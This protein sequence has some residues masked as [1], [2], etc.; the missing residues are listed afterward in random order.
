MHVRPCWFLYL[1]PILQTECWKNT[2]SDGG[3]LYQEIAQ[4]YTFKMFKSIHFVLKRQE[5]FIINTQV[6]RLCPYVCLYVYL[7]FLW[8]VIILLVERMKWCNKKTQGINFQPVACLT[9]VI[10]V[11]C[12]TPDNW[13]E[14]TQCL[15]MGHRLFKD[16]YDH[17]SVHSFCRNENRKWD[18]KRVEYVYRLQISINSWQF[19]NSY[20][21][22]MGIDVFLSWDIHD[23]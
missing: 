19:N 9:A 17:V 14:M 3:K 1:I 20:T 10:P 23:R 11:M 8:F 4:W 16:P 2:Q 13:W 22:W 15:T 5:Q 18:I 12:C 21:L 6:L 7:S